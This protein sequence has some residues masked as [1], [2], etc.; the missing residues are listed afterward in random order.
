MIDG[1]RLAD[2]F[3]RRFS[4]EPAL[5]RAPGRVN[6]IGEHTDY[7]DGFVMPAALQQATWIAIARRDDEMVRIHSELTGQTSKFDLKE[8][9]PTPRRDWTDY[10]RGVAVMLK[11][12]GHGLVGADILVASDVPVGAGLSSSAALEVSI[13]YAFLR[14]AGGE[15]GLTDLAQVCQRA[16]NEFVGM[17]CGIM[18]Q[19]VACKGVAGHA[20]LIDCRSLV[21]TPVPVD[22]RARLMICNSMVRHALAGSEYNRRR[23]DCEEAVATL[24]PR[25]PNLRALRDLSLEGLE[26]HKSLLSELVYRRCRH[27]VTENGRVLAAANALLAGDLGLCGRLMAESH[28]SLR[29]DYEVSCR[30][31]DQMVEIALSAAG[32]FGA[33]MTGGGFGGSVVALV[34]TDAV[35]QFRETVARGYRGATGL[36]PTILSCTPGTGVGAVALGEENGA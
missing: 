34:R 30:E 33:R 26:S 7:N 36:T 9:D 31:V 11:R 27:I 15:I 23:H 5:F 35:E 18:D 19:L 12:A 20:L 29:D 14:V 3:R 4:A 10:I 2:D 8:A 21:T 32:V 25:L 17:R 1:R 22:G 28:A 16:E 6:L 24:A 13:G